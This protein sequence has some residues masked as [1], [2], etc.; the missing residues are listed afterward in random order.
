MKI[1]RQKFGPNGWAL[2]VRVLGFTLMVRRP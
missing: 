1:T 2:Y